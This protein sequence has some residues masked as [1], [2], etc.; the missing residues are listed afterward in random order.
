MGF[1]GGGWM[2]MM[3]ASEEKPKVTRTLLRRVLA[4]AAPYRWQIVGMLLLIL[5]DTGLTLLMPL[6]IRNLIDQT[7]PSGNVPGRHARL[8]SSRLVPG[9]SRRV[10]IHTTCP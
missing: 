9:R 1:H 6:V 10:V 5:A 4:Y 8:N 7:I 2:R 3:S